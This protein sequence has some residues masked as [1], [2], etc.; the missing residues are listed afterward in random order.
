MARAARIVQNNF[1]VF[2]ALIVVVSI[3]MFV[4][5]MIGIMGFGMANF[6]AMAASDG[7]PSFGPGVI[8]MVLVIMV[9]AF[10][11]M[12][13]TQALMAHGAACDLEG[14]KATFSESWSVGFRHCLPVAAIML[15]TS[16]MVMFG[17]I[18]LIIP[19]IILGVFFS[20]SA[21]AQVIDKLGVFEAMGASVK[22]SEGNRWMLFAYYLVTF[23]ILYAVIII[24]YLLVMGMFGGAF[25]AAGGQGG[26]PEFT[27]GMVVAA[28]L[29][30]LF[31]LAFSIIVPQVTGVIPA[32]A[33]AQL[34]SST[35]DRQAASTFD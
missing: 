11:S 23:I 12:G 4:I 6:A 9:V 13:F 26:T 30:F 16:I 29:Y 2:S 1:L 31:I 32:A 35:G 25:L 8:G 33:Y 20:M 19:G 21:P 24:A 18:F 17:T 10:I 22:I 15:M 14:R 5:Q 27:G 28:I 7:Q 3:V 34:K